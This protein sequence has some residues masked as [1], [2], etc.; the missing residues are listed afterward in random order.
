VAR[1][2]FFARARVSGHGAASASRGPPAG[3]CNP[4]QMAGLG[5]I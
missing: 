2:H 4:T 3:Y 1:K 5:R